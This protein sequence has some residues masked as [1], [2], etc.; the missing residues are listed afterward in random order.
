M[1]NVIIA[2]WTPDGDGCSDAVE[3]GNLPF[4]KTT[5]TIFYKSPVNAMGIP[6]HFRRHRLYTSFALDS[7]INTCKIK[8]W[9]ASL[10][11]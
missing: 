1:A 6:Q 3:A 4:H 9:T 7:T 5:L 2:T 10:I 8:I 11:S